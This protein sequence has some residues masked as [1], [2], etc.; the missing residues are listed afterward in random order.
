MIFDDTSV[1]SESVKH[2]VDI[3]AGINKMTNLDYF[4]SSLV[5]CSRSSKPRVTK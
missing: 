4:N 3:V 2:N 1:V 5:V